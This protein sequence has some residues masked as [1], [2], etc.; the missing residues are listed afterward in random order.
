MIVLNEFQREELR[1]LGLDNIKSLMDIIEILPEFIEEK[2]TGRFDYELTVR[3]HEVYYESYDALDRYGDTYVLAS[4]STTYDKK[5]NSL[6]DCAFEMLKW[7]LNKKLIK[8][9]TKNKLS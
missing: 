1:K 2:G 3:K 6:L 7:C 5:C 9:D 8:S 4:F